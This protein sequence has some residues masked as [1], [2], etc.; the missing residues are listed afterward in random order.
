[1]VLFQSREQEGV[2]TASPGR[3][4]AEIS[5]WRNCQAASQSGQGC[6]TT[7]PTAMYE[8]SGFLVSL[9]CLCVRF[10]KMQWC[11]KQRVRAS[12]PRG[13]LGNSWRKSRQGYPA[14][15][16]VR[17]IIPGEP[18]QV[19]LTQKRRNVSNFVERD[20]TRRTRECELTGI[21]LTG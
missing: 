19:R 15:M 14:E 13:N 21:L 5:L 2:L 11:V 4:V 10:K 8:G 20:R 18:T 1:M 17:L 3:G 7:C 12:D 9:S 6:F 16:D